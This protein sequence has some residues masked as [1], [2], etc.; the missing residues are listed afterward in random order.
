M[1]SRTSIQAIG[2]TFCWT[3]PSAASSS[4]RCSRA[5]ACS[6]RRSPVP[7]LQL[8]ARGRLGPHHRAVR[9]RRRGIDRL[10]RGRHRAHSQRYRAARSGTWTSTI[11]RP[12]R[13]SGPSS[14]DEVWSRLEAFLTAAVPVAESAGVRL[15]AHPDDPPVPSLRD[16]ARVLTSEAAMQRLLDHV[17]SRANSLE[18]CQGTISEMPD[19]DIY[20]AIA[21]FAASGPDRL[22][23]LPQRRRARAELPRSIPRRGRRRH[24]QGAADLRRERLRRRVHPRPHAADDLRGALARWDGVRARI[25][26]ARPCAPSKNHDRTRIDAIVPMRRAHRRN[27][28]ACR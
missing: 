16:T 9:A 12:A 15:C 4:S 25:H 17:P 26:E 28:D 19:V 10:R 3:G 8:L 27:T 14:A 7:G 1:R 11:R 21:R 23:P 20:D 24:A 18:F 22:R 13:R 5:S 2:T 6:G